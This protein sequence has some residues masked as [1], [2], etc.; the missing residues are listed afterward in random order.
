MEKAVGK[1]P[2]VE[3][4]QCLSRM[5]WPKEYRP[6]EFDEKAFKCP[7]CMTGVQTV[8]PEEITPHDMEEENGWGWLL[9]N[10]DKAIEHPF[11][12]RSL[13]Y[14]ASHCDLD[15]IASKVEI[16][17]LSDETIL[18]IKGKKVQ[19]ITEIKENLRQRIKNRDSNLISCSLCF[20]D[21]DPSQLRSAC[22][23]SGCK[24]RICSDCIKSWYSLNKPGCIINTSAL[25][26]PFCRR[27]P[28]GKI[29]RRHR[30]TDIGSLAEALTESGTWIHAWCWRCNHA[31]EYMERV[32]ANGAPEP[33]HHWLCDGCKPV[34]EDISS[35]FCPGCGVLTEKISGC[36]HITCP[37]G[38]HWCYA[39]GEAHSAMNIYTHIAEKHGGL[40]V[41]WDDYDTEYDYE[42]GAE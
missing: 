13:F 8:V 7:G 4:G 23:R 35:K 24:Q 6:Q 26:C 10:V 31:R 15:N 38:E 20:S 28:A 42:S 27:I 18:T 37:C 17:P 12:G 25:S 40:E 34:K 16:L 29:A 22:G 19:N 41:E 11:N 9:K 30:I 21:L 14:T 36:H 5:I 3:C 2:W 1:A 32:C 39:C 33:V